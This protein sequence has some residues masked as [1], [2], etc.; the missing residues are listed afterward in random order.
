MFLSSAFSKLLYM[1]IWFSNI[2]IN[3]NKRQRKSKR[4]SRMDHPDTGNIGQ[5]PQKPGSEP[6]YSRRVSGSRFLY[7]ARRVIH[8]YIYIWSSTIHVLSVME[9]WKHLFYKGKDPLLFEI[10]IFRKG[11]PD[12]DDDLNFLLAITS[13]E[14]QRNIV[15]AVHV[16]FR[17]R[18]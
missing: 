18:L 10:W 4:Q 14:K 16:N 3:A 11:Q 13:T 9:E 8:I 7:E 1:H 2:R 5:T 12:N 15:S 6:R 17:I